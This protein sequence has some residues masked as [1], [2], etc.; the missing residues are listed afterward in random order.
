MS[1]GHVVHVN[2]VARLNRVKV[3]I[4]HTSYFRELKELI[5]ATIPSNITMQSA[6]VMRDLLRCRKYGTRNQ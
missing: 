4:K 3:L 6:L 1:T 5:I 2:T